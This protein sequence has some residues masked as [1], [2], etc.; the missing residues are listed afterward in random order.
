LQANMGAM[1]A[2][3][4]DMQRA[5]ADANAALKLPADRD[6]KAEAALALAF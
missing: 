3:L 6:V 2:Y 4:G 1:G 5:R